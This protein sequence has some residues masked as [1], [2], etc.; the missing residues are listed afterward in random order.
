MPAGD[1]IAHE[2]SKLAGL[3]SLKRALEP[4]ITLRTCLSLL[5]PGKEELGVAS[6]VILIYPNQIITVFRYVSE[7]WAPNGHVPPLCTNC[8]VAS[9]DIVYPSTM[10]LKAH[11]SRGQYPKAVDYDRQPVASQEAINAQADRKESVA[12][13]RCQ[14]CAVIC[15]PGPLLLPPKALDTIGDYRHTKSKPG[16]KECKGWRIYHCPM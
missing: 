8:G 6:E 3:I 12:A 5:L 10:A 4:E 2:V 15:Q 11:T 13:W 7:L 9:W 1:A 16:F 14:G